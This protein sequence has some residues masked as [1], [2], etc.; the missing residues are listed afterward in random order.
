MA[1]ISYLVTA[2]LI[3]VFVFAYTKRCFFTTQLTVQSRVFSPAHSAPRTIFQSPP[4]IPLRSKSQCL[5][6]CGP[7][8]VPPDTCLIP[9]RICGGLT[10]SN[11]DVIMIDSWN[12]IDLVIFYH[13]HVFTC[14]QRRSAC[15]NVQ[16][17]HRHLWYLLILFFTFM[18]GLHQLF[19]LRMFS[20][21]LKE[22]NFYHYL[23][24]SGSLFLS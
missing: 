4:R 7:G 6:R 8:V 22:M 13:V 15:T 24:R 9:P 18:L 20:L 12:K 17:D 5:S 19:S 1:L 3:C 21:L 11:N 14:Q 2:K 23:M 16:S 10:M